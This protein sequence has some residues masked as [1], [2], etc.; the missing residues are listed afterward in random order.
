MNTTQCPACGS[1]FDVSM[2]APGFRFRCS[3]C[4]HVVTVPAHGEPA[5]QAASALVAAQAPAAPPPGRIIRPP[6][7]ASV[8]ARPPAGA[9]P[10][11]ARQKPTTAR[12]PN[13][14]SVPYR[15]TRAAQRRS[16]HQVATVDEPVAQ[17]CE[18]VRTSRR[19]R[20]ADAMRRHWGKGIV[21]AVA[22]IAVAIIGLWALERK[23]F[24][25]SM[26]TIAAQ[27]GETDLPI[28]SLVDT[29]REG[30]P[31]DRGQLQS[32]YDASL[33]RYKALAMKLI[34]IKVPG[35]AR[36]RT[37]YD[38]M[39]R[40]IV[41]NAT[42]FEQMYGPLIDM[43]SSRDTTKRDFDARQEETRRGTFLQWMDAADG[44]EAARKAYATEFGLNL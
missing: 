4:K 9:V 25:D 19:Q 11:K 3:R 20:L 10:A 44:L 14:P 15:A 6:A 33:G 21:A 28:K 2:Y 42:I 17:S 34:A 23:R 32:A 30:Q 7:T 35:G 38:R 26:A 29:W 1:Q 16:T 24:Y 13:S 18:S 8:P 39:G 36:A 5:A 41:V 27:L 37:L 31:I 12:S 43:L 22:L 40:Y